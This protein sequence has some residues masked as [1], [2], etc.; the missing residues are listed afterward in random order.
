MDAR[1]KELVWDRG[2]LEGVNKCRPLE[3]ILIAGVPGTSTDWR[4]SIGGGGDV[5][6]GG[7]TRV[8]S[9]DPDTIEDDSRG[10]RGGVLD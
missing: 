8:S 9:S 10:L 2:R 5:G 1:P 4:S 3:S 6:G 7:W